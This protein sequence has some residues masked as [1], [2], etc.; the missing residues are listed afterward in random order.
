MSDLPVSLKRP[1]IWQYALCYIVWFAVVGSMIWL[2]V[3]G[4][5]N[6][7]TPIRLSG[8]DY[9]VVS[10]INNTSWILIGLTTLILIVV[11]EYVLRT[12]LEK[13]RFWSHVARSIIV[14]AIVLAVVYIGAPLLL[15][16]LLIH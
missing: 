8:I 10:V 14:E 9:R 5:Y 13:G 6:L 2:L 3:Q 15:K 11:L 7:I 1:S 16:V 4:Q 12:G